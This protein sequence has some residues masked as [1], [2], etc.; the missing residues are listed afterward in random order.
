MHNELNR[1]SKKPKYQCI[2]CDKETPDI[3]SEIWAQYFKS[4]DSIITDLFE[5][6]LCSSIN[7]RK[8]GHMSLTFDNFMDLSVS[9][10]KSRGFGSVGVDDLMKGFVKPE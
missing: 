2:D 10:P 4:D 9:I 6:Q 3:Q 7:C 1:I 8:C 5:G